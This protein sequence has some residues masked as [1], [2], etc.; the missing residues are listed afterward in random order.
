MGIVKDTVVTERG[1]NS[2]FQKGFNNG[3]LP[4]KI[5]SLFMRVQSTKDS[6]KYGW[7]GDVP[8]LREW[9]DERKLSGLRDYNYT[10]VNKSYE[11]TLAIDRDELEDDQIGAVMMRVQDLGERAAT[12][13]TKLI[14]DLMAAGTVG[15]AFD[16]L[17][18]F[19]AS[20]T[21]DGGTTT[22]T[23]IVSGTGVTYATIKADFNS[24]RALLRTFV[25][26]QGE[27][28]NQ[29]E[30]KLAIACSPA[31]EG[32]MREVFLADRVGGGDSN[33]LKGQIAEGNIHTTGRLS[34]NDWYLYEIGEGVKPFIFQ[35]RRNIEPGFLGKDSE[36]GFMRKHY[37][38]GVDYRA[39]M[40][41]GL[42][43]KAIMV[44][45]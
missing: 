20:H 32:I 42:W 29:G 13:P 10:I 33:T 30:L 8:Q 9:V 16:G 35:T 14:Y 34:G 43:Q 45:N 28:I 17:P 2:A 21:L 11:S 25:D 19:S 41:Y 40:A 22:Q 31:V 7:L 23:N 38:Y 36:E 24:A 15:L 1:L 26:N 6:E 44:N 3:E 4:A 12:H 39:R 27:V 37:K 18:F 5:E